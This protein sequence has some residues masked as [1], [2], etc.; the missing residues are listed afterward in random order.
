MDPGWP[1][2]SGRIPEPTRT[3]DATSSLNSPSSGPCLGWNCGRS[4]RS[5]ATE[6]GFGRPSE[7]G[8]STFAANSDKASGFGLGEN[9]SFNITAVG[10]TPSSW[11]L[12][13]QISS[14]SRR[15]WSMLAIL[16]N[17]GTP[18]GVG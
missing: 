9:Q 7:A 16:A 13:F 18:S 2:S 1:H 14:I 17:P 6:T 8:S 15:L 12:S 5:S 11:A 3:I 4:R 10:T